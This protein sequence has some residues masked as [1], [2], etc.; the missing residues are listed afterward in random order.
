M[1]ANYKFLPCPFCGN[2]DRQW[3]RILIDE[4]SEYRVRCAKCNADGP[5][6]KFKTLAVRAWNQ[7]KPTEAQNRFC[8]TTSERRNGG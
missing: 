4:E 2:G 5:I 8:Q 6:H 7:R 3:M 1:M